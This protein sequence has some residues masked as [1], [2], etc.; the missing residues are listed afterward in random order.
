VQEIHPPR[1]TNDFGP[2]FSQLDADAD[3]MAVM[4][5][6]GEL[7][8]VEQFA[9]YVKSHKLKV[10]DLYGQ[11]TNGEYMPRHG[12]KA[13]GMIAVSPYTPG[14]ELKENKDFLAAWY[15]RFPGRV[16]TMEAAL[17]YSAAEVLVAAIEKVKGNLDGDANKKA[18]LNAVAQTN[19]MT[20]RGPLKLDAH[21]DIVQTM[22]VYEVVPGADSVP[23]TKVIK[24]YPNVS[25]YWDRTPEQLKSF[26]FGK[27]KG[28][29]VGQTQDKMTQFITR[30]K[31]Q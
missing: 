29:W 26:S 28:T 13:I 22:Y 1:G 2:F 25:Q 6:G 19:V 30:P 31:V 15:A 10:I 21:Q 8:F 20:P 4:L 17:G 5:S 27:L 14:I 12:S 3:F 9:N 11:A 24:S 7:S 16:P 18:F 23:T